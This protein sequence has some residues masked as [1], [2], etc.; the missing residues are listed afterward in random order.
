MATSLSSSFNQLNKSINSSNSVKYL[1]YLL[2]LALIVG[3]I[4]KNQIIPLI[5][6]ILFSGIIYY[7]NKNQ[8]ISL[9]FGIIVTNLL[10]VLNIFTPIEGMKNGAK[11]NKLETKDDKDKNDVNNKPKNDSSSLF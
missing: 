10:I 2:S 7:F 6:F 4:V 11:K 1:I 8:V 3:Y 9:L 5:F